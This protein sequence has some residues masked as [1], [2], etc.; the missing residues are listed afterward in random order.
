MERNATTGYYA[1]PYSLSELSKDTKAGLL[2]LGALGMLSV[3]ALLPVIIFVTARLFVVQK[4]HLNQP[5]ILCFNLLIADLFQATA[6]LISFHW[7][8]LGGIFA[9]SGWCHVQGAL[10]NLGDLSSGFFV[11]FIALHTA[12]TIT[13]GKTIRQAVFATILVCIWAFAIILTIV[14][15]LAFGESF[16]TRAGNWVSSA[17]ML[18]LA[19]VGS[20]ADRY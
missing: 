1:E 5:I 3:T 19:N 9:P 16:F 10:L 13:S 20:L 6:F 15:P 14:G 7:V 8:V 4:L 18:S 2:V 17:L 11:L 12:Y